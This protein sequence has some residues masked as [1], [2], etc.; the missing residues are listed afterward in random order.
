MNNSEINK[1][2]DKKAGSPIFII[3]IF[4]ALLVV[5]FYVPEIYQRLNVDMASVFGIGKANEKN[6]TPIED[7]T[8]ATSDFYQIGSKSTLSFNEITL[9]DI[10][11]VDGFLTFT[12]SSSDKIDLE[13]L[14][15]Y[16]EF[17][18]ARSTFVGRRMLR[19]EVI[20]NKTLKID[21]SNLDINTSTYFMISHIADASIPKKTLTSDE[22][23]LAS[24]QCSKENRIYT[25]DFKNSSLYKVTMNY[26]YSNQSLE[27][28]SKVLFEYQKIAKAMNDL[29]GATASVADNNSTFIYTLQLD[30]TDVKNFSH[31][32]EDYIFKKGVLSHVI[33]FKMDAEGFECK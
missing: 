28:Y 7:T 17:Y 25:Y 29:T 32:T 15:Y 21:V 12:V 8:P 19:G 13:S 5:V 33:E 10:D 30:Y 2:K 31:V 18:E 20:K 24:L 22:S 4:V 14:N 11:L 27:E 26:T 3:V 9:S 1:E 6:D 16:L 23:G